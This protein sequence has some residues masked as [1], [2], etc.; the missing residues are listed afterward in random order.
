MSGFVVVGTTN[1]EDPKLGRLKK[2]GSS[3]PPSKLVL[4]GSG[5]AGD[6]EDDLLVRDA[7]ETL[8]N[9]LMESFGPS[10]SLTCIDCELR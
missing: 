8:G 4:G 7:R 1:C 3:S 6:I 5:G 2:A 10:V 9:S